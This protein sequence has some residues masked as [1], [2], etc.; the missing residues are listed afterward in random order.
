VTTPSPAAVDLEAGQGREGEFVDCLLLQVSVESDDQQSTV[1]CA[2]KMIR[3]IARMTQAKQVLINGFAG[4]AN[5]ARRPDPAAAIAVLTALHDR[6]AC[7]GLPVYSA[8]FGWE[9]SWHM[10]IHPGEWQQR[11]ARPKP[12]PVGTSEPI[13]RTTAAGGS[14]G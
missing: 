10:E 3:R 12:P 6:L 13:K 4:F 5:P 9:K 14:E 7:A 1:A 8:P 11:V 2:A